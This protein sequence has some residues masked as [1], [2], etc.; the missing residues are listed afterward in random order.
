M[1]GTIPHI[2][3][4]DVHVDLRGR[5][6]RVLGGVADAEYWSRSGF[7]QRG[8]ISSDAA[9]EGGTDCMMRDL[10]GVDHS[11][12]WIGSSDVEGRGFVTLL[13]VGGSASGIVFLS[14]GKTVGIATGSTA[15]FA[16]VSD[17]RIVGAFNGIQNRA[18]DCTFGPNIDIVNSTAKGVE[19]YGMTIQAVVALD[20]DPY[21]PSGIGSANAVVTQANHGN[22]PGV[23]TV[24]F[25]GTIQTSNGLNPIVPSNSDPPYTVQNP[26][27]TNT[28][29]IIV[30]GSCTDVTLASWGGPDVEAHYNPTPNIANNNTFIG[31]RTWQSAANTATGWSVGMNTGNP[32][33]RAANTRIMAC[34]DHGSNLPWED[35]GSDTDWA[36]LN[37]SYD[38]NDNILTDPVALPNN[39]VAT[40]VTAAGLVSA[41]FVLLGTY[42]F[43]INGASSSIEFHTLGAYSEI[44]LVPRA[45][46]H[47]NGSTQNW[48]VQGSY[49]N[50]TWLTSSGDYMRY[51]STNASGLLF[52][53]AVAAATPVSGWIHIKTF[54]L[55][56]KQ[57]VQIN[58]GQDNNATSP[59]TNGAYFTAG[60]A[61]QAV[62]VVNGGGVPTTGG[63]VYCL[64]KV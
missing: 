41:G 14:E 55:A 3:V 28:F 53:S 10:T 34:E 47:G 61:L 4:G 5:R 64:G 29:T 56:I 21:T 59:K 52:S 38:L 43:S 62:R 11:P 63:I 2:S 44:A 13:G 27:T 6:M 58:G 25:S 39:I 50:A 8:G 60:T 24:R 45:L 26:V 33:G 31:V 23:T 30:G 40:T 54:N 15:S 36:G 22:T 49:D 20:T 37:K 48:Q 18:S 19:V 9:G 12:S 35:A 1:I 46:T 32:D 42:D 57:D 17:C 7:R 51:G 16:R